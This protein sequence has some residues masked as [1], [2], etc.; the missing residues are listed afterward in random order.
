MQSGIL[1]MRMLSGIL[2]K[3]ENLRFGVASGQVFFLR[4]VR[5]FVCKS[6]KV[7]TD[8]PVNI[9]KGQG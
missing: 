6:F 8:P 4:Q 2:M 5:L 3:L 7:D 1:E 9:L